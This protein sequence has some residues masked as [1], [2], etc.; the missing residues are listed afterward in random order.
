MRNMEEE[1]DAN[2]NYEK[3]TARSREEFICT[4]LNIVYI[5][6]YIHIMCVFVF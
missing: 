3:H 5:Y 4:F 6:L 1:R 2:E